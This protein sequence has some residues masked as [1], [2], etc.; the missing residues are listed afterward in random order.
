MSD[1]IFKAPRII[2]YLDLPQ[3]VKE[4]FFQVVVLNAVNII[5]P[6]TRIPI[7]EIDWQQTTCPTLL[8]FHKVT[9]RVDDEEEFLPTL[10]RFLD[11]G[12]EKSYFCFFVDFG[13][14]QLITPEPIRSIDQLQSALAKLT[15]QLQEAQRLGVELVRAEAANN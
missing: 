12:P 11:A 6:D 10:V 4:N 5:G 3:S 13:S 14:G 7:S 15:W 9:Q 8:D 1:I 2:N